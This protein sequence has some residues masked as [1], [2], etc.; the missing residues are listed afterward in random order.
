MSNS[1]IQVT[2]LSKSYTIS[3][4]G[5][6]RYTSLRDVMAQKAKKILLIPKLTKPLLL[7]LQN[8]PN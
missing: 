7:S 1:I 5:K 8:L 6:K 3:H 2:N 4:E